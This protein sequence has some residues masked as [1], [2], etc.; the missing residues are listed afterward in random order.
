MAILDVS[1][2]V[3]LSKVMSLIT[4]GIGI[5]G[6]TIAPRALINLFTDHP[7]FETTETILVASAGLVVVGIVLT[8]VMCVPLA[9]TWPAIPRT[10]WVRWSRLVHLA[11]LER[12]GA[13][14]RLGEAMIAL[15]TVL[16]SFFLLMPA[17]W[18]VLQPAASAAAD[19]Q[20]VLEVDPVAALVAA[21]S[22]PW[23]EEAVFRMPLVVLFT[24]S[25]TYLA[26][27]WRRLHVVITVVMLGLTSV[28]FGQIH[29]EFSAWDAQA[30]ILNGA[31]YGVIALITRSVVPAAIAHCLFNALVWLT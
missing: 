11:G 14:R 5:L 26:H 2:T 9:G 28:A 10:V 18:M 7:V 4:L 29:G 15:A 21:A 8:T 19:P 22:G 24:L 6:A 30:N 25:G 31:L 20:D 12:R 3:T 27:P 1:S 13:K 23:F 17:L 16:A